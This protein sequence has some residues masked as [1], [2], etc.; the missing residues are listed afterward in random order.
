MASAFRILDF[1]A[2]TGTA[3]LGR[4]GK[5]DTYFTVRDTSRDRAEQLVTRFRAHEQRERAA[6][7]DGPAV[8]PNL[9]R[10]QS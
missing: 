7:P 4:E 10:R 5:P 9:H 1:D 8:S 2:T 6:N 3:L